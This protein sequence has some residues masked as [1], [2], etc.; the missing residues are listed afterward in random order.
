MFLSELLEKYA[1]FKKNPDES[2]FSKG[3]SS[4]VNRG[5][6]PMIKKSSLNHTNQKQDEFQNLLFLFFVVSVLSL[7]FFIYLWRSIQ[8][9]NLEFDIYRLEK[10]KKKLYE[11]VESL[12]LS[13]ANYS[14]VSRIE[15]LYRSRFGYLPVHTG[16][17][18]VTLELPKH[19]PEDPEKSER[20]P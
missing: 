10:E 15:K 1:E 13:V 12:K 8:F 19:P 7:V 2:I 16:K 14:T 3:I 4:G 9:A 20:E 5:P 18:I 11:E 17:S 6:N